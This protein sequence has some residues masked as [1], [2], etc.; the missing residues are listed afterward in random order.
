MSDLTTEF[1]GLTL[2]SPLVASA[3]PLCESAENISKLEDQGIAAV[4]LPSLFEE[5]LILESL[6]VDEV[7]RAALTVSPKRSVTFP[8]SRPTILGRTAISN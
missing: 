8:T 7:S 3:S 1:M 4:V 2:K 5:Q 6:H